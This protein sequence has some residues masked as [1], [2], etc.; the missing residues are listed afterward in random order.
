MNMMAVRNCG[1]QEEV[2]KYY[3]RG[4]SLFLV[5]TQRSLIVDKPR[6]VL[7]QVSTHLLRTTS[8]GTGA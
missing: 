5:C 3:Y 1:E 6:R 7:S 8:S 2:N 4:Q